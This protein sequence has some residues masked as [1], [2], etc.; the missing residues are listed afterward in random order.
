MREDT[1]NDHFLNVKSLKLS[2]ELHNC[3]SSSSSSSEDEE[4][5][6]PYD[7]ADDL[8]DVEEHDIWP[9]DL[10]YHVSFVKKSSIHNEVSGRGAG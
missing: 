10:K 9:V 5:S 8:A 6:G 7:S 4:L 3:R 2:F 1:R